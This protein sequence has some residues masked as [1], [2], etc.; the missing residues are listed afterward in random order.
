MYVQH[1]YGRKKY[2]GILYNLQCKKK[3][4]KTLTSVYDQIHFI[5]KNCDYLEDTQKQITVVC[6]MLHIDKLR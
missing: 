6:V 2:R 4:K 5:L 1:W 3:N